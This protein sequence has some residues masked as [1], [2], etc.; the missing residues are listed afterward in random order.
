MKKEAKREKNI[1]ANA[2]GISNSFPLSPLLF[3]TV[4]YDDG[5]KRQFDR[6]FCESNNHHHLLL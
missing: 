1:K 6:F 3:F 4:K 5:I 2:Q